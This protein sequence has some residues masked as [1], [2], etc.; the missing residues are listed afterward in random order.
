MLLGWIARGLGAAL[1]ILSGYLW[2]LTWTVWQAVRD[3]FAEVGEPLQYQ[4][5]AASLGTAIAATGIG[6][7]LSLLGLV[8]QRLHRLEAASERQ[9]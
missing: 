6:I 4:M 5:F 9:S 3:G 1:V 2:Y 8:L 7:V